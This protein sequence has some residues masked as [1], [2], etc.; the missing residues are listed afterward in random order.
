MLATDAVY[1]SA[2]SYDEPCFIEGPFDFRSIA[3]L[4]GQTHGTLSA[5]QYFA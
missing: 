5:P 4:N 2:A 3:I 1:S